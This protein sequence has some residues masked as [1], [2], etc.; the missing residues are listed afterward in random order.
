MNFAFRN[1]WLELVH[2]FMSKGRCKRVIGFELLCCFCSHQE[3]VSYFHS[4][5][6]L[7]KF[8]LVVL[9]SFNCLFFFFTKVFNDLSFTGVRSLRFNLVDSSNYE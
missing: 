4:N 3:G 8:R 2:C 1:D 5:L 7:L 6:S 9:L